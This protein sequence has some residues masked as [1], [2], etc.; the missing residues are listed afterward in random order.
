MKYLKEKEKEMP[1]KLTER[2]DNFEEKYLDSLDNPE[3][4]L[5]KKHYN[6]MLRK[7]L[8]CKEEFTS[9]GKHNRLCSH[10]RRMRRNYA[11]T[12]TFG[13]GAGR[14]NTRRVKGDSQ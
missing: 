14:V 10:C 6:T 11:D 8:K 7:C 5:R 13:L 2:K 12:D 3:E 4:R 1:K 9:E